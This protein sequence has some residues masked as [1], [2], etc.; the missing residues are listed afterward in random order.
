MSSEYFTDAELSCR[1]GCGFKITN[2]VFLRKLDFVRED[3]DEPMILN[4]AARCKKHNK[5]I[6]GARNSAH[7]LADPVA[8]DIRCK[9]SRLRYK[10]VGA[11]YREGFRRIEVSGKRKGVNTMAWIHVDSATED[12]GHQQDVLF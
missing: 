10:I 2:K 9:N 7:A 5:A 11:A 12:T 1:C 8:V 4:S 6:G 3:V